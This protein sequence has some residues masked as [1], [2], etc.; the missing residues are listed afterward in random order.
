MGRKEDKLKIKKKRKRRLHFLKKFFEITIFLLVVLVITYFLNEYVVERT[1]V[2]NH[3]MEPTLSPDDVLL[4]DKITYKNRD[5]KRYEIILFINEN[6]GEEL[7]KR[8]IGMPGETVRLAAG[9]IFINGNAIDDVE[10]L[11]GPFDAGDAETD[12]VL[13]DDEYFV[14][15]DN[16]KESIDSRNALVG[17]VKKESIIGKTLIRIKPLNK[18]IIK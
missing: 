1:A 5:P 16:R 7:V 2:H 4:T 17:P 12:F 15:G 9:K 14:L 6:D 8:V 3:S 13:E 18:M 11:D 10:G